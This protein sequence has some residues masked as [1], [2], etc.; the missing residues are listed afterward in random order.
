MS[1]IQMIKPYH[2]VRFRWWK[3]VDLKKVAEDFGLFNVEMII[4]PKIEGEISFFKAH[5]RDELKVKADTLTARLSSFKVLLFQKE[6]APLTTR[7][8]E[9]RKKVLELYPRNRST[10]FP[11]LFTQEPEFEVANK[12]SI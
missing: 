5:E 11:W 9:L 6:V 2:Y 12:P 8:M 1:L 4:G 7:D 3:R 10:P